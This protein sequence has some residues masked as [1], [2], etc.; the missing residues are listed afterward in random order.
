M[1]AIKDAWIT[2]HD[3]GLVALS[4]ES[5]HVKEKHMRIHAYDWEFPDVPSERHP[6]RHTVSI[7]LL[8]E[9]DLNVIL[10]AIC[11]YLGYQVEL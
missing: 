5:A 3:S 10:R 7:S 8:N 1:S 6:K 9:D 4:L 2:E 11:K